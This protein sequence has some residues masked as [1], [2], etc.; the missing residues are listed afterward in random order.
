LKVPDG[1]KPMLNARQGTVE[2]WVKPVDP[3]THL[4]N[5]ILLT[6]GSFRIM[7]RLNIGTYAFLGDVRF[8]R[9]FSLPNSR[10]T[11]LAV[12][13]KP[14]ENVNADVEARIYADGIDTGPKTLE[15]LK[16]TVPE[17]W[18]GNELVV[19]SGIF[20]G[21]LRVSDTV[22][23]EQNFSR[24]EAYFEA[25]KH[26]RVLY[27]FDGSGDAWIFGKKRAIH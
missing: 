7:R 12:T 11:H 4:S 6:C 27:S 26:T 9:F 17:D 1:D 8:D 23:Y 3:A 16:N 24:P 22:R 19:S 18:P 2:M 13:W 14:S 25:D 5:R 21:G 15:L 10:W 20:V